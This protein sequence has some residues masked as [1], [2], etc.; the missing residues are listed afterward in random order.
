M[1]PE[2]VL[3]VVGV[4]AVGVLVVLWWIAAVRVL[5]FIIVAPGEFLRFLREFRRLPPSVWRG[6]GVPRR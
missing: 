1:R 5:W 4:V 3:L 6:P 2:Q